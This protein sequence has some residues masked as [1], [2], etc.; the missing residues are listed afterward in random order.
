[1]FVVRVVDKM[2]KVL[3]QI[4]KGEASLMQQKWNGSKVEDP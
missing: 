4:G 2:M 3:A 1:M